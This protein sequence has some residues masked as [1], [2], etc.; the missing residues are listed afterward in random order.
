VIPLIVLV[1]DVE[2]YALG[3]IEDLREQFSE[4]AAEGAIRL[5]ST[6]TEFHKS[7]ELFA[8]ATPRLF[9]IDIMLRY[10]DPG[11]DDEN[12]PAEI[13]ERATRD[14]FYRAGIRCAAR[15]RGDARFDSAGIILHTILDK[16]D[17][18]ADP[19]YPAPP[20]CVHVLKEENGKRI[21]DEVSTLLRG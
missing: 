8:A 15:L 16:A 5:V 4:L 21:L 20:N 9:I 7:F 11:A 13:R 2:G 1:E 10:Q 3:L 12:V 19:D 18:D 6:E 17:L 14:R